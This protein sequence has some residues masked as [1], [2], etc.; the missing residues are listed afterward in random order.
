MS[1]DII[2]EYNLS[3]VEVVAKNLIKA[4]RNIS[5]L[6]FTGSLGA[7]K[8]TLVGTMLREMGVSKP[9]VSPTFTYMNVY[10]LADGRTAYHFDLYR[11]DS[12]ESF[13]Q[14]GFA[15]YLYQ[16]NSICFIEWPEIIK[17]LLTYSVMH[18]DIDFVGMEK[19]QL[20]YTYKK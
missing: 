14:A 6:T 15:D 19:R 4:S 17:P 3:E 2:L 13:E 7:G 9:V 5:V 1:T 8:T 16:D 18:V 11:L 10:T 12:L 20:T